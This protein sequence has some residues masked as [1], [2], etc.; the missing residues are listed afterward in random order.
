[1]RRLRLRPVTTA[2][3]GGGA[4]EPLP[5]LDRD[6]GWS[7]DPRVREFSW[8]ER[9]TEVRRHR[10]GAD[11]LVAT[12][13]G[14]AAQVRV[15]MVTPHV[16][17]VQ[18][19]PP[20][21]GLDRTS[22][23][24][25][26]R[27][28]PGR[29]RLA[30]GRRTVRLASEVLS[31][32]ITRRPWR[33]RMLDRSGAVVFAEL[34]DRG[35]DWFVTAPTGFA[36]ERAGGTR[37]AYASFWLR[38]DE[39]FYG[40][41]ER[42]G[43]LDRRGLRT[44]L[45]SVDTRS[46]NSTDA[47]YKPSPFFMSTAG[48]GMFVHT[49][50]RTMVDLGATSAISGAVLVEEPVLDYLL[51]YGPRLRD[52]LRRYLDLTGHPAPPP[53]WSFG[54]WL[55]RCMY[56]NRKE[57]EGVVREARRRDLPMDVIH[58]DP[59]WLAGRKGETFD[60]CDFIWDEHAFGAPGALV[61]WLRAR[62]VRLSLWENPY[63]SMA[64]PRFPEAVRRG[65][66]LRT[67]DGGLARFAGL[68]A[69]I[70][71]FTNPAAREW[72]KALHRPLL[73]DGVAVFKPDYGEAVPPNAVS[74][75][76]R[77]GAE[78]HNLYPLLFT[79]TVFEVTR[80]FTDRPLVWARSGWA[81]SQRYPLHWS[82]DAPSR[83]EVL[84]A[85]LSSGLSLALSG[86]A[87]WSHDIGGFYRLTDPELYVRWA[88]WGLLTS[89]ARFHGKEPREPWHIG[90][91]ALRIVRRYAHL[92]YRLLPYLYSEAV[93][94]V[95]GG[96]PL[97]RPLVLEFQDDPAV[98]TIADQYLLGSAL[99]VAPVFTPD[100]R[101]RI[102]L[103]AGRWWDFRT[104]RR[105]DGP[106][107]LNVRAPL[108]VL[109]LFVR[110]D[111]I[112]PLGPAVAHSGEPVRVLTF[113]VRIDGRAAYELHTETGRVTIRAARR[114]GAVTVRVRGGGG[115]H[116]IRLLGWVAAQVEVR[117]RGRLRRV[118]TGPEGTEV[119]VAAA[120]PYAVRAAL[121][122]AAGPRPRKAIPG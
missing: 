95:R 38:H 122:A 43:P 22:P 94:S 77:T 75:D 4:A 6:P 116:I 111:T 47:A 98:A 30:V 114:A 70:V 66:F 73:R 21:T 24:V 49:T 28:Q 26:G 63:I 3:E 76:G 88:Q 92:R 46:T 27:P 113:E 1:M 58:L 81:G 117:G 115:T 17:R 68:R 11:L 29:V 16:V 82:G 39:R 10:G 119:T 80:E 36:A 48:Y 78:V 32:E 110:S 67:P 52:I 84:P 33:L 7:F 85:I 97:M 14:P 57:V 87:F 89:H 12:S 72:Y 25:V 19:A 106:A 20:G 50:A 101:R 112:L 8:L 34:A 59:L 23:I 13:A 79:R 53:R 2:I 91:R 107:W 9:V 45:W 15:T 102:Y 104:G 60:T 31:V 109:P 69:A 44:V 74:H 64:S 40:L 65:F 37:A 120:G 86:F 100:G 35:D 83:W 108:D 51:I 41:G 61:R 56:R 55:S 62:G 5:L 42:Y 90:T 93:A 96:L 71:D 105:H 99:L 121:S 54:I 18:M 103:P 118:R